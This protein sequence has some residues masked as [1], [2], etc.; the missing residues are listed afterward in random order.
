MIYYA[1][2]RRKKDIIS[3][4]YCADDFASFKGSVRRLQFRISDRSEEVFQNVE[5]QRINNHDVLRSNSNGPVEQAIKVF[6]YWQPERR[7]VLQLTTLVPKWAV[8][9]HR[10]IFKSRTMKL[11]FYK[12][13]I[14]YET[15]SSHNNKKSMNY[16]WRMTNYVKALH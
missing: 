14:A 9:H 5:L 7:T 12:R 13:L 16:V 4:M 3:S 2:V 1:T 10:K 6:K 8:H 11:A 15:R